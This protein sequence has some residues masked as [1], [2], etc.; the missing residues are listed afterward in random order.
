MKNFLLLAPFFLVG[1][2][3][4]Q[5]EYSPA[6]RS[7]S[8]KEMQISKNRTKS[9]NLLEKGQIEEW[10]QTQP[11]KYYGTR[12]NYW[13]NLENLPSRPRKSNGDLISYQYDIYDFD[14]VKLYD[15]PVKNL[16]VNFGRFEELKPVEDAL[17]YMEEGEERTLLIPSSLAFG[18]VGDGDRILPDMP[19]IVKLK[20][21]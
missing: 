6:N 15:K 19:V 18:A 5:P 17:R 3:Q 8:E 2:V 11:E 9:L 20:V 16:N 13:I 1:C 10:I 7:M 14:W 12:L 4:H 21:L